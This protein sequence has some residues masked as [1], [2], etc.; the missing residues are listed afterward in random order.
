MVCVPTFGVAIVVLKPVKDEFSVVATGLAKLESSTEICT[1][2]AELAETVG[3]V[4]YDRPER[5]VKPLP[6]YGPS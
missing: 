4:T 2:R 5:P 6:A 3:I 1:E